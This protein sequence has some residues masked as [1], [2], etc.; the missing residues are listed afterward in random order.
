MKDNQT[1][2]I[3]V[4]TAL[5]VSQECSYVCI[6]SKHRLNKGTSFKQVFS[7]V[8]IDKT[9]FLALKSCKTLSRTD[10]DNKNIRRTNSNNNVNDKQ[11]MHPIDKMMTNGNQDANFPST[12]QETNNNESTLSDMAEEDNDATVQTSKCPT[13]SNYY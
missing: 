2:N 10:I 13:T 7:G 1:N 12:L 3:K 5:E 11:K 4:F 8:S 6:S 9:R